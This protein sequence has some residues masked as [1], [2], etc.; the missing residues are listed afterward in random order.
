MSKD[1]S[2]YKTIIYEGYGQHGIAV[3]V[4]TATDN[5]TRTVANVRSYFNK[6]DGSLGTSGS[7]EFMFEHKYRKIAA[8]DIDVEELEFGEV[9]TAPKMCLRILKKNGEETEI[10]MI[11]GQFADYGNIAKGL[12][13]LG[14]EIIESGFEYINY[15]KELDEAQTKDIEKLIEKLEEDDDVQNVYTTEDKGCATSEG[16]NTKKPPDG[17]LFSSH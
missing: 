6:C 2:D 1:Q 12:E 9:T 4:E 5:N 7:V 13:G 15:N 16:Q 17:R 3:L 14:H 8:G 10:I 11:Y